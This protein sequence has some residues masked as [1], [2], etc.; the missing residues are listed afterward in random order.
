MMNRGGYLNHCGTD[1][2]G[3]YFQDTAYPDRE[4]YL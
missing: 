4:Q 1:R 3:H 2:S